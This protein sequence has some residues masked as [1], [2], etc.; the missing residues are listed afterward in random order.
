MTD[1]AFLE[2]ASRALEDFVRALRASDV[3][4]SPAE[5]IDAHR[6]AMEVGF[7]DRALLRDALA[8]QPRHVRSSAN[9][10]ENYA[11]IGCKNQ[12]IHATLRLD[13]LRFYAFDG[14]GVEFE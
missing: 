14:A 8:E 13:F 2:P 4:V 3:R 1:S 12:F 7:A 9:S 5:A 10:G 6:A 11:P